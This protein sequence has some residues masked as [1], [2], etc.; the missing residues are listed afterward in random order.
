[1][2]QFKKLSF[3]KYIS[4]GLQYEAGHPSS[5]D[6]ISTYQLDTINYKLSNDEIT[7]IITFK[8]VIV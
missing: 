7:N 6:A 4:N 1:M 5:N 2:I 3:I 8:G